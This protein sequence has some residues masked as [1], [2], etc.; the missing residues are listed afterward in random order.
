MTDRSDSGAAPGARRGAAEFLDAVWYRRSAWRW[1]LW[2][3]AAAFRLATAL[4]AAAYRRGWLRSFSLPVP[5][6]VVGNVTVGGTGKTPMIVWLAQ[7]LAEHGIAAGIVTRG[8]GGAATAWPQW[9]DR[10]SDPRI[11][12]D[13]PV[14]IAMRTGCPVVAG[15]DRVAAARELLAQRAVDV[16]LSDDGL[17]HYRMR[18]A[19]EIAV[20]DGLRGVGNGLCLP[21][22]PLREPASRLAT[23]DAVVVNGGP[24]EAAPP[25]EG[26]RMLSRIELAPTRVY[27]LTDGAAA[28]LG[29][30]AGRRVHAVAGIGHPE[31]FFDSLETAGLDVT[32]HPLPDH[33]AIGP[34]D[35]VHEPGVPVLITEKDAVKCRSID[36]ADVWVVAVDVEIEQAAAE[37]LIDALLRRVETTA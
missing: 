36:D 23:V 28:S 22:G 31:R 14:L 5:V 33:A 29:D 25:V 20:V 30:F 19:F 37:R 32:R 21:A 17:Q 11:V 10:D 3:A 2:P 26:A 24:T 4:R 12:G 8:Y 13:E 7:R 6:V 1:P 18:R 27:R 16:L 9:V 15:P 35:L 34:H